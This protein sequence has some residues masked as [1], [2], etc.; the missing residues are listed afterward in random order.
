MLATWAPLR[1]RR[2]KRDVPTNSPVM[3]WEEQMHVSRSGIEGSGRGLCV[4]Y[5]EVVSYVVWDFVEEGHAHFGVLEGDIVVGSSGEGNC[6]GAAFQR[7][8]RWC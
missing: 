7:G 2:R 6:E 4:A 3:A 8:L 5:D 1:A